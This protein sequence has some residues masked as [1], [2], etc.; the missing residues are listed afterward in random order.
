MS[1]DIGSLEVGKLADLVIIDGNPL[2]NIRES[3]K[4]EKVMIN[5]RLFDANTLNEEVT[6]DRV[7]KPFYWH[8]KPESEIR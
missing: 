8:G 6:G 7:T 5:G 4:V 2:E 3:D 1:K